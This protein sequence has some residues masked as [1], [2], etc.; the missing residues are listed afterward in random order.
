[1]A[2]MNIK[3]IKSTL[4]DVGTMKDLEPIDFAEQNGLADSL[5]QYF[6]HEGETLKATQLRKI[7]SS[8][9]SIQRELEPQIRKN[10]DIKKDHFD[11]SD[12]ATLLVNLAYAKG[13]R[14]I[15][16]DFY[17]ILSQCL[18]QKKLR[19]N[20]DFIRVAEFTE[21][22]LAYYKFRGGAS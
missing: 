15:P 13:R 9:K 10:K 11:R 17:D 22:I 1:M 16:D 19:T 8:I 12:I 18:S 21:A 4:A 20:A 3:Q 14:L 6:I 5:V 7:F 2:A